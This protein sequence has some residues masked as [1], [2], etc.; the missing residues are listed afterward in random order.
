VNNYKIF[1]LIS[2]NLYAQFFELNSLV[3]QY[4]TYWLV[5]ASQIIY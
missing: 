3:V 4:V 2:F 5:I 1:N